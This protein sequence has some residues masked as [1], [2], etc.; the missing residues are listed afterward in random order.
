MDQH[1]QIKELKVLTFPIKLKLKGRVFQFTLY[2]KLE[3]RVRL[4]FR[5][6]KFLPLQYMPTVIAN[7][8]IRNN[9]NQTTP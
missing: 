9:I 2:F 7:K 1:I 5:G 4:L 8:Q 3:H 6:K